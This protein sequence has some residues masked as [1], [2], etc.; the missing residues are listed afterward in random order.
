MTRPGAVAVLLQ[1][2][3]VAYADGYLNLPGGTSD[4]AATP[5]SA[6]FDGADLEV[7]VLAAA[8]DWTPAAVAV[9]VAKFE[10]TGNQKSWVLQVSTTGLLV[11]VV[12][13]DGSDASNSLSSAAP[14]LVDGTAYWI[15]SKRVASTGAVTYGKAAS[16][17]A[18]PQE[19]DWTTITGGTLLAGQSPFSS[20]AVVTVG[21]RDGIPTGA[22]TNPFTGKIIAA[23]ILVNGVEVANPD[24]RNAS[25]GEVSITDSHGLVWTKN[26]SAVVVGRTVVPPP[27]VPVAAAPITGLPGPAGVDWKATGG[28]DAFH[29]ALVAGTVDIAVL[30]NSVTEGSVLTT[31]LSNKWLNKLIDGLRAV[32]QPGGVTGGYGYAIPWHHGGTAPVDPWTTVGTIN[33]NN[34][35]LA[36]MAAKFT[37]T[38]DSKTATFTGTRFDVFWWRTATGGTVNVAID[39]GAPTA[40][41]TAGADAP[42]Q[43]T[44][45]AGLSDAAHTIAITWVSGTSYIEGV[46]VYRG[47]EAVGIRGWGGGQGGSKSVDFVNTTRWKSTLS[48]MAANKLVILEFGLNDRTANRT[49]ADLRASLASLVVNIRA[50]SP[51]ANIVI[52]NMW[53]DDS[54]VP[55]YRWDD[56]QS[57]LIN[58]VWADGALN[59]FDGRARMGDWSAGNPNFGDGLHPNET[60]HALIGSA[61]ASFLSP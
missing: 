33:D 13:P 7:Q 59:L 50:A 51:T 10:T 4:Y 55:L 42:A 23:R 36:G 27:A 30:G 60:G 15:R 35:G 5:D 6:V 28:L 61:L 12:S 43:K 3:R 53:R 16:T 56:Y 46:M 40:I 11:T 25:G 20:S 34:T 19:S 26:G 47:D 57:E 54:A 31:S 48:A 9:L 8:T 32:Y 17:L 1:R 2:P 22:G 39:G 14:G 41:N 29:I 37:T 58:L 52:V 18:T 44:S 49:P 45:F 38:G 21:G 24:W